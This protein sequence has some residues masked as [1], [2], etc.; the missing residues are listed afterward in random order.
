MN[1]KLLTTAIGAALA[2]GSAV[3]QADVKVGGHAQVEYYNAEIDTTGAAKSKGN[4][5]IDNARG[6]FWIDVQEDLGA[7]LKGLAHFEFSV[8]TANSG[9]ADANGNGATFLDTSLRTFDN[10]TRE[11]YVGLAGGFG[12]IKA[13]NQHGVYKRLGGVRWDPFNATVLEARGNG[14]QSG[15]D[16]SASGYTHNAFI[17]GAIKWESGKVFGDM[18]TAE[19]LYSPEKTDAGA[20]DAG[21]GNDIGAGVSIKPMKGFEIIAATF[22]NKKSPSVAANTDQKGTK[23]GVRYNFMDSH[24]V[25]LQAEDVDTNSTF[26]AVNSNGITTAAKGDAEFMWLGY[27]LKFGNN[28]LVAQLGSAE[29][30]AAAV[31]KREVDYRNLGVIHS[32]SKTVSSW[33]GYRE[34]EST[35][36]A[37]KTDTSVLALGMRV[38]F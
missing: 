20:G 27:T 28:L 29:F 10:R 9:Q 26:A 31:T 4:G 1:K 5:L 12:A 19:L 38:N 6:R 32:F 2:A 3:G 8:D 18:V 36:G 17:P 35:T 14:G 37:T 11:K 33:V 34:T 25:W 21:S 15:T 22:S 7:G 23:L 13:G 16:V 24:T 30:T